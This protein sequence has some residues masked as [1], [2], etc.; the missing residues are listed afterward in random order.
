MF[1]QPLREANPPV[2]KPDK[3][4]GFLS[5]VF[6]NINEILDHHQRMLTKLFERQRE[7]HPL[8]QSVADIILDSKSS[9][10]PELHEDVEF[11]VSW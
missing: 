10:V 6:W 9:P 2:I 1:I 5:E 11:D 4:S 3:L 7:Q 8:V